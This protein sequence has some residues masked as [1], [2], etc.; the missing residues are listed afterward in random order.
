MGSNLLDQA[1]FAD[2][3]EPRCPVVLL[4]DTSGSMQ[5]APINELNQGLRA[6]EAALKADRLASL[7]VEVALMTFGGGVRLLDVRDGRASEEGA[8]EAF[9]TAD[10]FQAP[11]LGASGDTPMGEAVSRSLDLIRDRKEIY[12]ANALDY[13]RPWMFLITDGRPT[14]SG[15]ELAADQVR[16]EE[17]RKG[18]VFYGVGVEKADMQVLARFSAARPPLKLK[19]LA[20]GELFQ[21]LS[22]SLSVVAHSRPGE[23]A[24]LPPVGWGEIDTSHSV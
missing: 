18:V 9:I 6:F 17:A 2:N 24:P 21:W 4:L 14:D 8:Q 19:G 20:F 11:A 12:K 10:G 3:P 23:Q 22:K 7:R 15:W 1:E 16:Q 5:G 13:F